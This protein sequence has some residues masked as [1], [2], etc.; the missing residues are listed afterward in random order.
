MGVFFPEYFIGVIDG[1]D[2]SLFGR[3]CSLAREGQQN[4]AEENGAS[5]SHTVKL[6]LIVF[7]CG[8]RKSPVSSL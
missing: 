1:W 6:S 7:R 3:R 8:S 2:A 4:R 5:T